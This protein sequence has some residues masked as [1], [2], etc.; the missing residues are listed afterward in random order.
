MI[1]SDRGYPAVARFLIERGADL[2]VRDGMEGQT[3][4]MIASKRGHRAMAQL[5]IQKGADV[6]AT[7]RKGRSA[8]FLALKGGH[9][10]IAWLLI[11]SGA[12]YRDPSID[13]YKPVVQQMIARGGPISAPE[14]LRETPETSISQER[15]P[16]VHWNYSQW[17]TI[18]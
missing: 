3:L 4:L 9:D 7:D 8:L 13:R 12:D 2:S 10:A 1:A 16:L 6:L 11:Q 14:E 5:L 17:E 15:A 18:G